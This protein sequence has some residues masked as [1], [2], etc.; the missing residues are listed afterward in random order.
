MKASLIFKL[1]IVILVVLV[2][3]AIWPHIQP[4]FLHPA[5]EILPTPTKRT[6]ATLI[7][8]G[9]QWGRSTCYIG[10]VEGSSRF[11]IADVRDLGI[12]TYRIFGGMPR[13]EPHDDDGFYGSPTIEQIKANPDVIPWQVWDRAMTNPP[14]GSD[15][16]WDPKQPQWKGSAVTLFGQ[17]QKA[18]IRTMIT[19]RNQDD[20]RNPSWAP[21]PP[22]TTADWNEWWEHVF[23]LVYWLNVRH[24][25]NI[26]DFEVHNEP[27]VPLQGWQGTRIQYF[28]FVQYTHDAIDYVY[29]TYLPGQTYH[30]YAPASAAVPEQDGIIWPRDALQNIPDAFDSISFHTY[31]DNIAPPVEQVHGWMDASKHSDYP[32]WLT[33]WGSYQ[34]RYNSVP[35]SVDLLTNLIRTSSPGND[36]VYG[37]QIF[38]LYDYD[39]T[40]TGLID[41]KG[42]RRAA[43]YAM[44]MGIRALQGCRP[45]YQSIVNQSK[46]QAITTI[47]ADQHI[48][49]LVTNQDSKNWYDVN[50]DLSALR[51]IAS[52]IMWQFDEVHMDTSAG[53]PQLNNGHVTFTIPANGAMLL[54]F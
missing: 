20:Q 44:H 34:R 40:F 39:T 17:L 38:S 26:N 5:V 42:N 37:S 21:N 9:T 30:I 35:F 41:Y 4:L 22:T 6:P 1:T 25:F 10:A 52:G 54:K 43:Y 18:G 31:E 27:N 53:N 23:A 49:L 14:G 47:D 36:Y 2:I 45:T 48:Y 7:V 29:H 32:L 46:L 19:L 16:W 8:N 3:F 33:E 50:T 13:W 11:D 12:N 51:R 15:Y 28:T 24:H